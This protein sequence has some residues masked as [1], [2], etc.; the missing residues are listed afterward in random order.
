[1]LERALHHRTEHTHAHFHVVFFF[2]AIIPLFSDVAILIFEE[3]I[4]KAFR[5][6]GQSQ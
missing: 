6:F 5:R 3:E 4:P 1:M 2:I